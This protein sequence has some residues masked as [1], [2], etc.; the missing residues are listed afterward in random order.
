MG[1]SGFAA[2]I[3]LGRDF[4][5]H[6]G[7]WRRGEIG[8]RS[9]GRFL[10]PIRDCIELGARIVGEK[11]GREQLALRET[12]KAEIVPPSLEQREPDFLFSLERLREKGKILSHELFL[13]IDG[14]RRDDRA[15]VVCRRP[16]QRRHQIRERFSDAGPRLQQTHSAIVV[17]IRDHAGHLA[18]ALAVFV[19][20]EHPRNRAGGTKVLLDGIAIERSALTLGCVFRNWR[21]GLVDDWKI[22]I[23]ARDHDSLSCAIL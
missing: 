22:P 18:L 14:V 9:V 12:Q 17:E 4:V 10:R 3:R 16:A 13:E 11:S 5:P 7:P 8:E 2:E 1:T 20:G 15:L 23:R 21:R 6:V 19:L